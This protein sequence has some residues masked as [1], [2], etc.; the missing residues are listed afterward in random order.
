[1]AKAAVKFPHSVVAIMGT[2][3]GLGVGSSLDFMSATCYF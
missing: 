2:G 3:D 1:M